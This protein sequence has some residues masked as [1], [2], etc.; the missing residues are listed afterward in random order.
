MRLSHHHRLISMSLSACT[1]IRHKDLYSDI[2]TAIIRQGRRCSPT[3]G[4]SIRQ[5]LTVIHRSVPDIAALRP[6][7]EKSGYGR[8]MPWSKP[9]APPS[10]TAAGRND[11]Q[12]AS[13]V[14]R[15]HAPADRGSRSERTVAASR[16][17]HL[18]LSLE[19]TLSGAGFGQRCCTGRTPLRARSLRR[20]FSHSTASPGSNPTNRYT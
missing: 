14:L 9:G 8:P 13:P 1:R 11:Q 12:F 3:L 10:G 6:P 15:T 5:T 17:R 19:H 18:I 2:S 4:G 16:K 7:P 20:G